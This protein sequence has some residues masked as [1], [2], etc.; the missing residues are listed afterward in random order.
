M[1]WA[2]P[3][4]RGILYDQ[5][6]VLAGHRLD[7][8]DLVGRWTLSEGD[9]FTSVRPGTSICSNGTALTHRS[10]VSSAG[11]GCTVNV[12][13]VVH[14]VEVGCCDGGADIH[15]ECFLVYPVIGV[16]VDAFYP[17]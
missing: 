8:Q 13:V 12:T 3:G 2:G 4:L 16:Q 6:H 15:A 7:T 5:D 9:F 10:W 1:L 14:G 17:A 11:S